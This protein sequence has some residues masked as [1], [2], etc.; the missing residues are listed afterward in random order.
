MTMVMLLLKQKLQIVTQ[1]QTSTDMEVDNTCDKT[2][3][4]GN[5]IGK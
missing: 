1:N 2:N 3:A 5:A 4:F